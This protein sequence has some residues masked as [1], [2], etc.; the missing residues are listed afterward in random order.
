MQEIFWGMETPVMRTIPDRCA[1]WSGKVPPPMN[2]LGL[3]R[4]WGLVEF[5]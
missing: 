2:M 5:R 4:Y 1:H 3:P